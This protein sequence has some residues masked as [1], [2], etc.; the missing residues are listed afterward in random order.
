M[1]TLI[2]KDY[3]RKNETTIFE[4]AS[5]RLAELLNV[6]NT[7]VCVFGIRAAIRVIGVKGIGFRAK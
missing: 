3:L 2:R 6:R 5:A 4:C 1:I 7:G